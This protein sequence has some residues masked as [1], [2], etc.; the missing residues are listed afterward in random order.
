MDRVIEHILRG[1]ASIGAVMPLE[2][3][4]PEIEVTKVSAREV[5]HKDWQQVGG[6]IQT[7]ISKFESNHDILQKIR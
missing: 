6:D 5:M 7:A 4:L 1:F 2:R 3:N